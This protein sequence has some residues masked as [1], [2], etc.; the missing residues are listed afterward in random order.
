MYMVL[1]VTLDIADI[2]IQVQCLGG[3]SPWRMWPCDQYTGWGGMTPWR[4]WTCD[5]RYKVWEGVT[6]KT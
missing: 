6:L 3:V 1:G 2:K 5:P 4:L